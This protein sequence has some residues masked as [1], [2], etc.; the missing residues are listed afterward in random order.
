[1][2]AT[3][4][5][6][7]LI[8]IGSL[9]SGGTKKHL[10]QVVPRLQEQGFRVTIA[11]F[12]Q[13]GALAPL[14]EKQGL[15]VLSPSLPR[16]A[17][18]IKPIKLL[19]KVLWLG[20]VISSLHPRVVHSFLPEA[21]LIGNLWALIWRVPVRIMSRRS[22]NHYQ[23]KYPLLTRLEHWLHGSDMCGT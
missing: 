13:P 9:D 15:R 19:L 2:Q 23:A 4:C 17:E 21:Y 18:N 14:F 20:R 12:A 6:D 16:W 8:V 1:M 3:D 11:A 7:I 10:L 22:L 5:T